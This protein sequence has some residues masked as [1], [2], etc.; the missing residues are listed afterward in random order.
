VPPGLPRRIAVTFTATVAM[1]T[2][3]AIVAFAS[4]VNV[5]PMLG[6]D[7]TPEFRRGDQ[8]VVLKSRFVAPI[9]RSD[10]VAYSRDR[11]TRSGRVARIDATAAWV[12]DGASQ[13]PI[14]R[15]D[16]IGRVVHRIGRGDR[17]CGGFEQVLV[18][19]IVARDGRPVL[20][21]TA[22]GGGLH[23]RSV[24]VVANIF[25]F[26]LDAQPAADAPAFLSPDW[27]GSKSVAQVASGTFDAQVLA[28]VRALGQ[29]VRELGSAQ[30]V[31]FV[32]YWAGIAIDRPNGRLCGAAGT[33]TPIFAEGY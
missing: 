1:A 26:G 6:D 27:M 2:A 3:L 17:V 29:E 16:V 31:L 33:E 4:Q 18:V 12:V 32:G 30:R 23:Q 13:R 8:L 7:L 21:S 5:Y 22:I 9:K 25:A 20:A 28:G 19:L 15:R 14:P 10:A 11:E 24:Q